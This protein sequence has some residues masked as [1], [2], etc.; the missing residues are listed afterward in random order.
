MSLAD[1]KARISAEA[2]EQVRAIEAE[3]NALVADIERKAAGEAKAIRDSYG[4]RL[5]REEPE[6]LKRREIVAGS[7]RRRWTWEFARIS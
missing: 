7:T 2:Q 3:N 5:A 6:V 4:E 1:I